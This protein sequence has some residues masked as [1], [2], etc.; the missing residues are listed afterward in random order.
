[1]EHDTSF[2]RTLVIVVMV[3]SRPAEPGDARRTATCR[4]GRVLLAARQPGCRLPP[5]TFFPTRKTKVKERYRRHTMGTPRHSMPR[6]AASPRHAES[7]KHI[8][9]ERHSTRL[10]LRDMAAGPAPCRATETQLPRDGSRTLSA[11]TTRGP[12]ARGKEMESMSGRTSPC[13]LA[14][15]GRHGGRATRHSSG[16]I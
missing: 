14:G 1:M 8:E 16:V 7:H 12:S 11:G 10:S 3:G 5:L 2:G 9:S 13:Q 15:R 4:V 6:V